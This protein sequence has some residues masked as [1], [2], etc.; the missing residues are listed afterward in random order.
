MADETEYVDKLLVSVN[1]AARNT[2]NVLLVFLLAGLYFAILIGATTDEQILRESSINLPLLNVTLP[3]V[4]FYVAAGPIYV[5]LH[6]N[7]LLQF[8]MLSRRIR[9][10][11]DAN[12]SNVAQ[13]GPSRWILLFP[14]PYSE[15]FAPQDGQSANARDDDGH[16]GLI[17]WLLRTMTWLMAIGIP[18]FLLLWMQIRFL[19]YQSEVI[20]W[21]HRSMLLL[22]VGMIAALLPILDS[23]LSHWRVGIQWAFPVPFKAFITERNYAKLKRILA[24]T[25]VILGIGLLSAL[26]LIMAELYA[27]NV[28]VSPVSI[29][30]I[31]GLAAM[32]ALLAY[33][34][35][36][37]GLLTNAH[38]MAK[39]TIHVTVLLA[40]LG[41]SILVGV[42][43][44]SW[45]DENLPLYLTGALLDGE[46]KFIRRHL[47]I[48]DKLLIAAP[49]P[50]ATIERYLNTNRSRDI[51]LRDHAVGLVLVD[52]NLRLADF[53]GS[54]LYNA[55]FN[56]ARM[57]G[58]DLRSANLE[59]ANLSKA[60]MQ[61]AN[62]SR[63]ILQGADLTLARL[64]GADLRRAKL[65]GADLSFAKLQGANLWS[66]NLRGADLSSAKLQGAELSHARLL[67]ANLRIAN[68][69]GAKL[70]FARLQGADFR[71]ANL[72]GAEFYLV[73]ITG[74]D[75]D[76][77]TRLPITDWQELIKVIKSSVSHSKRRKMALDRIDEASKR[78]SQS[79]D[80]LHGSTVDPTMT[81]SFI[82]NVPHW[83][84]SSIINI[85]ADIGDGF[86]VLTGDSFRQRR[87]FVL[88]N[89]AC[90][91]GSTAAEV[92]ATR[93]RRTILVFRALDG[94][95]YFYQAIIWH[96]EAANGCPALKKLGAK[97]VFW[98]RDAIEKFV[99]AANP[100]RKAQFREFQ[101]SNIS[102]IRRHNAPARKRPS[103]PSSTPRPP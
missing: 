84:K 21:L 90:L 62:L 50:D 66:A 56:F 77:A 12:S 28:A 102:Y 94:D 67:G 29:T 3:I 79:F 85:R 34:P 15:A 2:R 55:N 24:A 82:G 92:I 42:V 14:L 83:M 65:Q 30:A 40:V 103:P 49:P 75:F 100:T 8:Y 101:K 69:E 22:D 58:A 1:D 78:G 68:L 70:N 61:G 36:R 99:A 64:Q 51:A 63:A 60:R 31:G 98:L 91:S 74:A 38:Y 39:S 43:P 37:G 71:A 45:Q 44:G 47:V 33:I 32:L 81:E 53:R 88:A 48:R 96:V 76:A 97:S 13:G 80:S 23:H 27:A 16:H 9:R 7:L 73:S 25:G 95:P 35:W 4:G 5:I 52:C 46:E 10:F 19:A 57:Q 54:E 93:D 20:T 87:A 72:Q 41:A 86:Q 6:F 18:I 26:F 17:G 11:R 59:G 89:I